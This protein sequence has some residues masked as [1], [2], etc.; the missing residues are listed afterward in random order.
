MLIN[1][2]KIQLLK[3]F[4]EIACIIWFCG[5]LFCIPGGSFP[6]NLR[7]L[8]MNFWWNFLSHLSL[9][10]LKMCSSCFSLCAPVHSC[11]LMKLTHV[12][13]SFS[14]QDTDI[15]TGRMMMLI[16]WAR[17]FLSNLFFSRHLTVTILVGSSSWGDGSQS[18][19]MQA[20]GPELTSPE[21][22]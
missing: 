16:G 15:L 19:G 12:H 4:L 21:R 8:E 20:W 5:V 2:F 9:C 22:I 6:P 11:L 17:A 3:V 13:S 10:F 7:F 14:F 18:R 1:Y